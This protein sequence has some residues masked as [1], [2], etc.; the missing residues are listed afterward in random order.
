MYHLKIGRGNQ[1]ITTRILLPR[2]ENEIT[3]KNLEKVNVPKEK[4]DSALLS[5]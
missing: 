3:A 1:V 5:L 2:Y 4:F